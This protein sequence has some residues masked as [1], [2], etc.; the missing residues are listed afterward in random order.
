MSGLSAF[1]QFLCIV[2]FDRVF[3]NTLKYSKTR[4]NFPEFFPIQN[5]DFKLV[6]LAQLKQAAALEFNSQHYSK[7][8][9]Y[10]CKANLSEAI[11]IAH[12][13]KCSV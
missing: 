8:Q 5:N 12:F 2:F 9:R 10:Q 4:F 1:V 11:S 3:L 13:F 7:H 6:V